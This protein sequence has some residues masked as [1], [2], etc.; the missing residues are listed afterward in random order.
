[1]SDAETEWSTLMDASLLALLE[2][3][4]EGVILFDKEGRCRMIGRRTGELFGFDPASLVGKPQAEVLRVL[5]RVT[6]EPDALLQKIAGEELAAPPT[7]VTELAVVQPR[8]RRVIWTTFPVVRNAAVIARLILLRDVTRERSAER[9]SKVLSAQIEML[10]PNDTLTGLFNRRRFLEELEREH[11]RSTRAWDSYAVLRVDI[12]EMGKINDEFGALAGDRILER[13]AQCL[14]KCR[15]E[16][17]LLARYEGDEFAALLP[18][19]DA[20][21]AR[22]VATRFVQAVAEEEFA[23]T[24]TRVSVSVGCAVWAPP[25]GERGEDIFRRA[26]VATYRARANGRG[27]IYLDGL[28]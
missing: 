19:A 18:G 17:D 15:R 6:E 2:A 8:P 7:V 14:N 10:T 16:Y 9:A 27:G 11:G 23:L 13:V 21:A 26:G 5:V 1:M 3:L 24:N 28:E 25:S 12:D 4:D 22:A 20:V